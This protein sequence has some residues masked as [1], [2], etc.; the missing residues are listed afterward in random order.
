MIHSLSTYSQQDQGGRQSSSRKADY[1]GF[2]IN[3]SISAAERR[4]GLTLFADDSAAPRGKRRELVRLD[5][6]RPA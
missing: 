2:F 4:G 1:K 6:M 5:T 3:L